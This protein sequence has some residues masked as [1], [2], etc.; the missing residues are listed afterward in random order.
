[1]KRRIIIRTVL[2]VLFAAILGGCLYLNSLMPIITGYGAKNM[3]SAVFVS[4]RDAADVQALDLN[5]SF[6]KFNRYK[7]DYE[8]RTVTS[9]FLWAKSVA[10]YRDG[11]GVTLLR[12]KTISQLQ[13]EKYPLP[14]EENCH[15][16]CGEKI[17]PAGDSALAERLEPIARALVDEKS[18]NGTP[19]AFVVLHDGGVVA[20]RYRK[21]IEATTELLS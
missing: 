16:L 7:I 19:F 12:G 21:G 15:G 10:V 3:A 13:A 8:N 1:M 4:G 2:A 11:Y 17:L 20:E 5:F 6:I 9:R 14:L 18:Y